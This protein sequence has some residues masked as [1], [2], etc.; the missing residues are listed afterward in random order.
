MEKQYFSRCVYSIFIL[1]ISACHSVGDTQ[2]GISNQQVKENHIIQ[3][4]IAQN[5]IPQDNTAKNNTTQNKAQDNLAK[6]ETFNT[7]T[8]NATSVSSA[9]PT[10]KSNK[11]AKPT[12]SISVQLNSSQQKNTQLVL[13]NALGELALHYSQVFSYE[14]QFAGLE[15]SKMAGYVY[16]IYERDI[17]ALDTEYCVD[18]FKA[19]VWMIPINGGELNALADTIA[20]ECGQGFVDEMNEFLEFDKTNP[21]HY[22]KNYSPQL[23]Q[24]VELTISL[25]GSWIQGIKWQ[26]KNKASQNN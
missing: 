13:N 14:Q 24:R 8:N 20:H 25:V 16:E 26:E 3:N 18:Y 21:P 22:R 5:N 4:N 19:V 15:V 2:E 1:F 6:N 10:D 23:Y 9:I 7:N 17:K 12:N 11:S